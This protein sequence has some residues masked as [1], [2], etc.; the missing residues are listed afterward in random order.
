MNIAFSNQKGGVGKTTLALLFAQYLE[1]VDRTPLCL[2]F[3]LQASLFTKFNEA[4]QLLTDE[5]KIHVVRCRLDQAQQ[6]LEKVSETEYPKIFDLPGSLEHPELHLLFTKMD[7]IVTPF[8]YDPISFESTLI[9]AQILEKLDVM[10]KIVFVPNLVKSG[11]NYG[12]SNKVD[13]S[14]SAF[15]S[16]SPRIKDWVEMQRV[17]FFNTNP[18][19]QTNTTEAYDFIYK[20]YINK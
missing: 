20:K 15:G 19:C 12:I 14:L 7:L 8:I 5:P 1:G 18:R 10:A 13:K 2:D 6:I 17:E 9:F 11:A 3:D 16:V 4:K